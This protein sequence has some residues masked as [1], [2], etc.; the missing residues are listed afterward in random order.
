M[1]L[2]NAIYRN[3]D[4]YPLTDIVG[5]PY[6]DV[7]IG[8]LVPDDNY[9]LYKDA[10]GFYD[11][12]GDDIEAL[13]N[14]G[15][16]VLISFGG[17]NFPSSAYQYYSQNLG[18]LVDQIVS[19]VTTYGF[20]GVDIDYEDDSG[21]DQPGQ[22]ANYDGAGFLVALT[23]GLYQALP[24]GQN[25]ITHAPS[26]PFWD[27]QGGFYAAGTQ[28][29]AYTQIWQ[30]VGSQIAWINCQFYDNQYYD[31]DAP[32]KV[33]WYQQIAEITGP[34]KL[35]VGALVGDPANYPGDT[36]EGYITL[37]D[38]TNYVIAPLKTKYG[39]Q[40]GGVMGWEFAQ[41]GP[42]TYDQEG[43]W[44]NGIGNAVADL[45]VFYQGE[46]DSGGLWYTVSSDSINWTQHGPVPNLGMSGS[47][48]AVLWQGGIEVFFQGVNNDGQL[49]RTFSADGNNW[50][51]T[52]TNVQV[53]GV[54][55]SGSPSCVVL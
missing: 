28:I 23:S 1:S 15:K 6:T 47:P 34:Q 26:P 33:N 46:G 53:P 30:Q 13:K 11:T 45:F 31:Q 14:G 50:G 52:Q 9:N 38:M 29:A 7:I 4:T 32:T 16:N 36:D 22:P 40:F 37:D 24:A 18:S 44:A 35:L 20:N 49:W 12:Y 55:I 39:S 48:S 10:D 43:A 3:A 8:F 27:P 51:T 17:S 5:L 41:D 2:R 21:F 42:P 19:V 25:L 54:G